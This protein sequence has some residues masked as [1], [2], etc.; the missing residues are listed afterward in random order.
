MESYTGGES[1][2]GRSMVQTLSTQSSP[3]MAPIGFTGT[4]LGSN[5]YPPTYPAI[6][7]DKG[8]G[9]R[10]ASLDKPSE[11]ESACL[12]RCAAII[13]EASDDPK[14]EQRN[15][16]ASDRLETAVVKHMCAA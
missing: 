9:S 16:L 6:H 7:N 8:T 15:M 1:L 13:A 4:M 3:S 2:I 5:A 14:S 11:A 12:A 10:S